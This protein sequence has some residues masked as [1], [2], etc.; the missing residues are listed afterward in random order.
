[1]RQR[2]ALNDGVPTEPARMSGSTRRVLLTTLATAPLMVLLARTA[3]ALRRRARLMR[4]TADGS[5]TTRCA[6]CGDPGHG[7]LACPSNPKLI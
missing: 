7:M 5:S 4:P 3:G 2:D 6:Q 1:M